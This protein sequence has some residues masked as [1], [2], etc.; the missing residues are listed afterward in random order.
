MNPDRIAI[1]DLGTNTFHLLIAELN[2]GLENDLIKLKVP[3]KLGQG[4]IS[5]GT[6]APDAYARALATLAG[7]KEETDKYAVKTV[8]A[9][10]T[11]AVRNAK[12][13]QKLVDEIYAHFGWEVEIIPGA[14]EAELIYEGVKCA[15][16]IGDERSL[17][18]DIG[19]GSVEFIICTQTKI[20]WKQSFEVGAQ[21]LLDAFH[22]TDPITT[23]EVLHL[24]H[25]LADKLQPLTIAMSQ[26]H[27]RVLI[28]SSGTFDTLCDIEA[29][30]EN[31]QPNQACL[32]NS[33]SLE[34]FYHIYHDLLT[35]TRAQ[36]LQTP[37]MIEMRVDMIVVAS[38]LI[39][40]VIN[41]YFIEKLRVSAY[42]LKEGLLSRIM[43]EIQKGKG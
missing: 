16:D 24:K 8:R 28:G 40:F 42:A 17:V 22:R 37:G 38:V 18:M 6:I 4:G 26:Y 20:F 29:F 3:V 13:G 36:R 10:A 1:I 5:R 12:N 2:N 30:R 43:E 27:P 25:Y 14:L 19:G 33:L 35:K 15:L 9:V 31:R 23:T 39:D 11:S 34:N 21:R 7:F 41:T 32:E